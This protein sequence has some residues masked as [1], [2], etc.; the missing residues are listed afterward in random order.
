M[1]GNPVLLRPAPNT[2]DPHTARR[3]WEISADLTGVRCD[4]Q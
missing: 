4:I 3:L 1:F 2:T